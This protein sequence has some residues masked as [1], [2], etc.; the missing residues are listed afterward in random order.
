MRVNKGFFIRMQ[1]ISDAALVMY[2][3]WAPLSDC[4]FLSTYGHL[5][6]GNDMR[7]AASLPDSA[8]SGGLMPHQCTVH[9]GMMSTCQVDHN[10]RLH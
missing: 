9:R 10:A 5:F 6:V 8:F 3:Q 4:D 7:Q 2:Q 1:C